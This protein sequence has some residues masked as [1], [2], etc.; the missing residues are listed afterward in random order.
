MYCPHFQYLVSPLWKRG[1]QPTEII[2]IK[3]SIF[4]KFLEFV[5]FSTTDI[6]DDETAWELLKLSDKYLLKKLQIFCEMYFASRI[7]SL[8]SNEEIEVLARE[9]KEMNLQALEK[10]CHFYL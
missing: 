9:A 1:D 10:I 2:D 7:T 4:L 5:Y 8:N 3:Y 6:E